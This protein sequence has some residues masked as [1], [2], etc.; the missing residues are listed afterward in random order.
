MFRTAAWMGISNRASSRTSTS[1]S[2]GWLWW[3]FFTFHVKVKNNKS[4]HTLAASSWSSI[5]KRLCF[6][7][8]GSD[9]HHTLDSFRHLLS[10]GYL[11]QSNPQELKQGCWMHSV[12]KGDHLGLSILLVGRKRFLLIH[13]G[14]EARLDPSF[15]NPNSKHLT[16]SLIES[17]QWLQLRKLADAK[18]GNS[19]GLNQIV[20]TWTRE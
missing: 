16:S 17:Q 19:E 10:D 14:C 11:L 9:T 5:Y 18:T 20:K 7:L 6:N 2:T 13:L 12:L 8:Q 1:G 3:T 4:W 15:G